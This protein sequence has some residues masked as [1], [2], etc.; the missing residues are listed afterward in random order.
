LS[1][2]N[3][4]RPFAATT[5]AE[6]GGLI[7]RG[8]H[9]LRQE[10]QKTENQDAQKKKDASS[11]APPKEEG[12]GLIKLGYGLLCLK[13]KDRL[14]GLSGVNFVATRACAGR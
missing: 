3:S 8:K 14:V 1:R 12:L 9:A 13:K 11:S 10:T 2:I 6:N 7:E 5:V 4:P